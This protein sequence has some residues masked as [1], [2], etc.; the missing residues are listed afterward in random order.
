MNPVENRK[1]VTAVLSTKK[2]GN[3]YS[4]LKFIEKQFNES[5]INLEIIRLFDYNIK[6]CL[7]CENCVLGKGC[8]VNDDMQLIVEMM[9]SSDGIII[10]SPV[11]NNN[12][13]G[14]MKMFIDKTVKWSHSPI[15]TG[16]PFLGA[17]TT[18]SSGL[19]FVLNY[20][21]VLGVNWG[22]HPVGNV[23]A[24]K[25]T[26]NMKKN[27]SVLRKFISAVHDDKKN[28]RPSLNQIIQFQKKKVL[29]LTVF[30]ND[31]SHWNENGWLDKPYYYT[32]RINPLYRFAGF[33]IY[34]MLLSI[35]KMSVK[36]YK[37]EMQ[38]D[39][40]KLKFE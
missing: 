2:Q 7:G 8:V 15:L 19:D 12:I 6:D 35:M 23:W 24:S 34:R 10:A 38:E 11:Y 4:L 26:V 17:T 20:F 28:H 18:S 5:N 31:Y 13:S 14:K 29:A 21:T 27:K 36:K 33:F 25:R 1:K 32:C 3:T 16:I 40:G 22:M 37:D 30:P 9:K 39:Y